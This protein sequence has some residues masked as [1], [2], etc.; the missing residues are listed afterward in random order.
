VRDLT[1]DGILFRINQ[2][3]TEGAGTIYCDGGLCSL[4][5]T[6]TTPYDVFEGAAYSIAFFTTGHF[7]K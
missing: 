3:Q 7:L 1:E 2:V 6:K 4:D 5:P